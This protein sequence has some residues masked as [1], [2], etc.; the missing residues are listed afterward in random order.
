MYVFMLSIISSSVS[1]NDGFGALGA[2]G[3]I[4]GKTDDIALLKEVLDIGYDYITVEYEFINE[5]SQD[6]TST[7]IFPLPPYPAT[8]NE[9]GI[10]AF[11][12]PYQFEIY[13]NGEPVTYETH[14]RAILN[15]H[16]V[17]E[18][19]KSIGFTEQQIAMFP[20]D[21]TLQN[22][23]HKLLIPVSQIVALREHGLLWENLDVVAWDNHVT[24]QWQQEFP[25]NSR[26][27]VRHRYV[28]FTASG[29]TSRFSDEQDIADFCPTQEQIERLNALLADEKNRNGYGDIPGTIVK[30]ILTTAN[31]WKDGIRDFTLRIHTQSPSEVVCLCFKEPLRQISEQVYEIHL[32]N[33]TPTSDLNIYFGNV[34]RKE[35]SIEHWGV[36]PKF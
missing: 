14:V 29:T 35:N 36:S 17:T 20:F 15:E 6:I 16:D 26:I 24:Y 3:I 25:A 2:G 1:G 31:T 18:T 33:F 34:R 19:L 9:G 12:Q 10:V 11:G 21:E 27:S 32:Q 28:P 22:Q 5:S 13:V 8:P 30:Y 4:I 23:D 7:I